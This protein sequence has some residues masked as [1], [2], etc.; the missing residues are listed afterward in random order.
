MV[1][2]KGN[3]RQ[4]FHAA[5][6]KTFQLTPSRFATENREMLHSV[7]FEN[8]TMAFLATSRFTNAYYYPD[9]E[10]A[11]DSILGAIDKELAP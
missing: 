3:V 5:R 6:N 4:L 2:E 7:V 10:K 11:I 8:R 9:V 1:N